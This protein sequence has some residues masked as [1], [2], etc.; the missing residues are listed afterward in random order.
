M[1]N[2][3]YENGFPGYVPVAT[4]R[5]EETAIAVSSVENDEIRISMARGGLLDFGWSFGFAHYR[6]ILSPV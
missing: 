3:K 2:P 4:R 1:G 6:G 5:V